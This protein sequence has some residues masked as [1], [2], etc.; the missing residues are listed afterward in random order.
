MKQFSILVSIDFS[1]VSE[2]V[3]NKAIFLSNKYGWKLYIAHVV[4]DSFFSFKDDIYKIKNNCWKFLEQKFPHIN[5]DS[6]FISKG[7]IQTELQK[8][9]KEL[10]INLLIIG[11]SGESFRLDRLITGST[12]KKIIR[13]SNIPVLV[14][15]ND[16][17][18]E[19]N[20]IL[21]PTDFSN[22]SKK[23]IDDTLEIFDNADI[24]LLH[25]YSIPFESRLGI[26]GIEKED[27]VNFSSQITAQNV[28]MAQKFMGSLS[29]L[30]HNVSIEMRNDVLTPTYFNDEEWLYGVDLVS[31]HTT[32][33]I[34]FFTFDMLDH[35]TK[36]VLIFKE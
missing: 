24:T 23:A 12:T 2:I 18:K 19:Y 26:Y 33:K 6:F 13:S 9:E 11:S 3:L 14:I 7:D 5:K 1:K 22:E 15:K 29:N 36:D 21:M 10:N 16:K 27:A 28:D 8:L 35:S 4:E 20:K 25:I 31:L 30:K 34:S 32:G 17:Q